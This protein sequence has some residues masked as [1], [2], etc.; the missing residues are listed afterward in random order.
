[1]PQRFRLV[2]LTVPNKTP[3]ARLLFGSNQTTVLQVATV[4]R[5]INGSDWSQSHRDR[6]E[7]PVIRHQVRMRIRTQP[8]VRLQFLPE[9]EQM[10]VV[11]AILQVGAS[12]IARRGVALEVNHIGDPLVAASEKVIETHLVQGGQG[13]VSRDMPAHPQI[14]GIGPDDHRHRIPPDVGLDKT[15]HRQVPGIGRFLIRRNGIEVGRRGNGR[16]AVSPGAETF[17]EIRHHQ[18]LLFGRFAGEN[19]ISQLLQGIAHADQSRT[20]TI[21]Q[22]SFR[23]RRRDAHARGNGVSERRHFRSATVAQTPTVPRELIE[24]PT[25]EPSRIMDPGHF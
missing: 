12:V 24:T 18:L 25:I 16:N 13:G 22:R 2:A 20:R 10:L 3:H 15:F 1:M 11:Q 23:S 7:L 4:P 6:G 21:H 9:I 5:L 19:D 17:D 8:R 14:S